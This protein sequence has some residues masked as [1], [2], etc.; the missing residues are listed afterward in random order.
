MNETLGFGDVSKVRT[1][2]HK[3]TQDVRAVKIIDKLRLTSKDLN[4]LH[5]EIDI[6]KELT[7]PNIVKLFEVYEDK[8]FI[9]LVEELFEGCQ[10]FDEI[11]KRSV[12]SEI[13]AAYV[14]KQI[15]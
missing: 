11:S 1:A 9:Y 5:V 14:I 10:I 15:L 3:A 12:F 4:K 7:H 13:E 6:L 2:I 8:G